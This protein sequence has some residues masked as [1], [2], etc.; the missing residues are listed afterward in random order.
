MT[1]TSGTN[2]DLPT[3]EA[4]RAKQ[5][6]REGNAIHLVHTSLKGLQ[7]QH[8]STSRLKHQIKLFVP[9]QSRLV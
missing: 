8:P 6:R 2:Q 9:E 4:N 1:R 3:H 5:K 7:D